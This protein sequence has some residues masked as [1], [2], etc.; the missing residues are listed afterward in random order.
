MFHTH[1]F[2]C[3]I[4]LFGLFVCVVYPSI[5]QCVYGQKLRRLVDLSE[6]YK[7]RVGRF[8]SFSTESPIAKVIREDKNLQK[9]LRPAYNFVNR[10]SALIEERR[11]MNDSRAC[12][13]FTNTMWTFRTVQ[14]MEIFQIGFLDQSCFSQFD[15]TGAV[16]D[17]EI[18]AEYSTNAREVFLNAEQA[19]LEAGSRI[20]KPDNKN[21]T[22]Y[23]GPFAVQEQEKT[24]DGQRCII[25]SVY[26][27]R[28]HSKWYIR[29]QYTNAPPQIGL[30]DFGRQ[31]L[32]EFI[33]EDFGT[34]LQMP[35]P[36]PETGELEL[37]TTVLGKWPGLGYSIE[38]QE[39]D[40]PNG[41]LYRAYRENLVR[42]DLA[43]DTVTLSNIAIL[44]LPMAM[45]FIPVAFVADPNSIGMVIYIIVTDVFSTVPFFIKGIEL[46]LSSQP[47]KEVVFALF[48]GNSTLASLQSWAVECSGEVQFRITGIVFVSVACVALVFGVSLEVWAKSYMNRRKAR[49]KAGDLVVGPFGPAGFEETTTGLLG[50]TEAHLESEFKTNVRR[51]KDQ[52]KHSFIS[53]VPAHEK[54]AGDHDDFDNEEKRTSAKSKS[55]V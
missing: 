32:Q 2:V 39:F 52:A 43:K 11:R 45:N 28:Q 42:I 50:S 33:A 3:N 27:Y 24:R 29:S 23:E 15:V 7:D 31:Y 47:R 4:G 20:P 30:L 51:R 17:G 12:N 53:T 46:I 5:L 54:D 26:A 34:S 49:A 25:D 22:H 36:N 6:K 8:E 38:A 18:A 19:L 16:E 55:S 41:P 1:T 48:G 37:T 13:V 44:A 21:W 40:D 9:Q 10:V 14:R 35:M